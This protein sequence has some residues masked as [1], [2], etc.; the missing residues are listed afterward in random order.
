MIDKCTEMA[1]QYDITINKA[2]R[3][4]GAVIFD[5]KEG[6]KKM[7]EYTGTPGRIKYEYELLN[8]IKSKGFDNVDNVIPTR[9]GEL[10]A[11]DEFGNMYVLKEWF[12]GK[13]CNS[14][15]D[16]DI[17][18]G[19]EAL[20]M[21]HNITESIK[22][23]RELAIGIENPVDECK[24]HNAELKRVRNYMR[25]KK[26]KVEFEYDILRHFDEYYSYATE[27]ALML[28]KTKIKELLTQV[29]ERNTICHGNFNYHNI[30]FVGEKTAITGFER[31]GRGILV[32]D[33]YFYLRKV[34]E[35]HDWNLKLG[36]NILDKYNK[37]R[38][39][40]KEENEIL[41][42][43]LMYPEKFW[44]VVNHYY[45]SNK[46]WIP[47]K[48]IEKLKAVYDGQIKKEEFITKMWTD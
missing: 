12:A 47:D 32:K 40:N 6:L 17:L 16:A 9:D 21:L 11:K 20:A 36:Y 25:A 27:A 13:D 18:K 4:R 24:R 1:V 44:K 34:M 7:Y 43:M 28:E 14:R 33:L 5:T 41:K 42:I 8:Y 19:A 2:I 30:M 23:I 46:S 35:K 48:N 39:I 38:S 15:N 29:E 37:I 22:E 26:H 45:N 31:S 3:G 10:V